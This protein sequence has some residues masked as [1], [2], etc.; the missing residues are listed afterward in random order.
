M[1]PEHQRIDQSQ[2]N[3]KNIKELQSEMAAISDPVAYYLRKSFSF[4]FI[5]DVVFFSAII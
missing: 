2:K 1:L 3:K 4:F 5:I